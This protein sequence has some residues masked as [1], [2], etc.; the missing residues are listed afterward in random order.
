SKQFTV[1]CAAGNPPRLDVGTACSETVGS[2]TVTVGVRNQNR[3][4]VEY[5]VSIKD[6][7]KKLTVKSGEQGT[8]IFPGIAT[9][10]HQV[11]V[12]SHAEDGAQASATAK[13]N[14]GT[15]STTTSPPTSSTTPVPQGRSDS[16]LANTGA[17]VGGLVGLGALALGL[18]GALLM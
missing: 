4:A 16:G 7:I 18:G 10:E 13:L 1:S 11:I 17:S 8:V 9:G 12:K 5:D 2:G 15:T 6:V 14:C 3:S